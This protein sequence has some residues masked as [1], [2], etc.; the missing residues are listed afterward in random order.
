M[1]GGNNLNWKGIIATIICF[2]LFLG[3]LGSCGED[4]EY[5][6]AGKTFG[7][8][9]NSD[10]NTWSDTEKQYFNDFMSWADGN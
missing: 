5:E 1:K 10:P 2:L 4:S 7:S 6:K 9:I 8:W 3:L